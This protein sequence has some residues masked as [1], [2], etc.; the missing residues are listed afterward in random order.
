MTSSNAAR[1]HWGWGWR[2]GAPHAR[3][4]QETPPAAAKA[5]C[6]AAWVAGSEAQQV[7]GYSMQIHPVPP[8]VCEL[9]STHGQAQQHIVDCDWRGGADGVCMLPAS[10]NATLL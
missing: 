3:T 9:F 4:L 10:C 8:W 1:L 7:Q 5:G 6:A 2:A